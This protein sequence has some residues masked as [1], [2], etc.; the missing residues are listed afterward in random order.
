MLKGKILFFNIKN[1]F[2]FIKDDDGKEYYVHAK[3]INGAFPEAGDEVEFDVQEARRGP[4]AIRVRKIPV[5]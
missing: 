4:E 2:G 3:N 5:E 1:K